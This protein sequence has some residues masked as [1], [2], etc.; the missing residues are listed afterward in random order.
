MANSCHG[1]ATH[2]WSCKRNVYYLLITASFVS[3]V[4]LWCLG[5]NRIEGRSHTAKLSWIGESRVQDVLAPPLAPLPTWKCAEVV[6]S[7]H[8]KCSLFLCCFPIWRGKKNL[9]FAK[10]TLSSFF[11]KTS[12][13]ND[14]YILYAQ[15]S[16]LS[17]YNIIP[18]TQTRLRA[19]PCFELGIDV[20]SFIWCDL[21]TK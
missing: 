14:S 9:F 8:E 11:L 19:R 10:N 3:F 13:G 1:R 4:F 6:S 2:P 21:K 16:N 5:D 7:S 18:V 15:V 17:P 12:L 20:H